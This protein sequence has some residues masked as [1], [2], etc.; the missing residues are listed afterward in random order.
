M[1]DWSFKPRDLVTVPNLITYLRFLLVYPFI[2]FFINEN[3]IMA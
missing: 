1:N 3:Y 2:W